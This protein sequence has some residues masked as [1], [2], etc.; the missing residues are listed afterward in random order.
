MAEWVCA[1]Y[2]PYTGMVLQCSACNHRIKH[3]SRGNPKHCPNC[4]RGMDNPTGTP[5]GWGRA[6]DNWDN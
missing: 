2:H 5:R 3:D 1:Y 6:L 4:R